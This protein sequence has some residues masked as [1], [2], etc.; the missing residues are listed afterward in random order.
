MKPIKDY[1]PVLVG[2]ILAGMWLGRLQQ[3]VDDIAAE[4]HYLHGTITVPSEAK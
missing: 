4:Q 3:R 1:W 2:L